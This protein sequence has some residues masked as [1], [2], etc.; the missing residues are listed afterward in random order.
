MTEAADAVQRFAADLA[1]LGDFPGTLGIAVSGGA[2]SVALLLLAHAAMGGRIRA[3]TVDHRLRPEAAA[4]ALAVTATCAQLGVLHDTLTVEWDKSP[5]ANVQTRARAARYALLGEWAR[6][7]RLSAVMTAHH[8]DDQAETLLMRLAR[9]SG[10]AGL[11]GARAVARIGAL[12]VLRPLLGWRR[13]ELRTIVDQARID[14]AD[15]KSNRDPR[16][17]RVRMR[18]MLAAATWADPLRLAASASH[19]A[20]AEEALCFI[21]DRLAEERLTVTGDRL[22]I[23]ASGLPRELQRRLLVR[24]LTQA[25]ERDL[26]GPEV[27][28]LLDALIA[29]NTATLGSSRLSGGTPWRLGPCPPH[30]QHC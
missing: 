1:A 12:T 14:P 22:E 17:D 24:A 16:F 15:D 4:E 13:S 2:D 3:A 28:R 9:G 30:R 26:R 23:D 7:H 11:A 29:G 5:T 20:A 27:E 18:E 25:G 6:E 19:L 21:A 8:A 10:V